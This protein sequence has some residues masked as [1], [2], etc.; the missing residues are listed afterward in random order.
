MAQKRNPNRDKAYQIWQKSKGS[1]PLKD[2]A[3]EI[4]VTP[5]TIRKWKSTDKWSLGSKRSAPIDKERYASMKENKN[6][7]GNHG[8][9]PPGNN[10]AVGYGAPVGNSNALVTGQYETIMFDTMTD[11]ELAMFTGVTDDPLITANTQIRELKIRQHRIMARLLKVSKGA[12]QNEDRMDLVI[13]LNTALDNVTKSLMQAVRQKQAIK[14]S[15]SSE[16]RRL[17]SAEASKAEAEAAKVNGNGNSLGMQKAM[18]G[19]SIEELRRLAGD[20]NSSTE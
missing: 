3:K 8:G 20:T 13:R 1:K 14:D 6:A 18:H 15:L 12:E 17:L 7:V 5:S 9:A 2:I 19:M 11:D 10:N 16:R 4:G